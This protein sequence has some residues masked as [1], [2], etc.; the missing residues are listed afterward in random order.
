MHFKT[1][2]DCQILR[3]CGVRAV[4]AYY[5]DRKAPFDLFISERTEF[6][7]HLH[8]HVEL[9]FALEGKVDITANGVQTLLNKGDLAIVFPHIVHSYGNAGRCKALLAI[10][11][12]DMVYGYSRTLAKMLPASPIIRADALH[13]DIPHLLN[14]LAATPRPGPGLLQGYLQ[15]IVG[16]ALESLALAPRREGEAQSLQTRLLDYIGEHYR[17]PLDLDGVAAALDVSKYHLSR[18]FAQKIGCGFNQYLNTMRAQ[19]AQSLLRETGLTITE[20]CYEAGFESLS[21]FYR[22]FRATFGGPPGSLPQQR[23]TTA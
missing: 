17:E 14:S 7:S 3:F 23:P 6:F 13:P 16:R 9:L 21:T 2:C 4:H 1:R 12:P 18:C 15:V 20:A 19:Y 8:H 22:A 10:F 5:E 11:S